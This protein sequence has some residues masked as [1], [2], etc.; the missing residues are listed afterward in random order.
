MSCFPCLGIFELQV[1]GDWIAIYVES[2]AIRDWSIKTVINELLCKLFHAT[3]LI[4]IDSEIVRMIG[5]RAKAVV[6]FT[7]CNNENRFLV[8]IPI[9][10]DIKES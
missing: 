6:A 7:N 9:I 2:K 8:V 3:Q 1:T 10:D 4:D 5:S